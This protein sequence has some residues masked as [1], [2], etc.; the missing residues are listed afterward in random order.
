MMDEHEI[1]VRRPLF[2][3]L[4]DTEPRVDREP[5][6]L[7]TLD[8]ASLKESV[9]RELELL[10]NTRSPVPVHRIPGEPRSVINYGIPDLGVYSPQNPDHRVE[11]AEIIRRAAMV[12]EPRLVDIRVRIVPVPGRDLMLR[13]QIDGAVLID[14][15]PEQVS[16]EMQPRDGRVQVHVGA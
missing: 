16:F 13:A 14:G 15:V 1:N 7:R 6:P 10:F 12:Y 3:R 2:D 11:L 5:R 8:R 4:V 9:R